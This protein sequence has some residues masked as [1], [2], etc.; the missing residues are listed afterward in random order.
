VTGLIVPVEYQSQRTLQPVP[1]I[2]MVCVKAKD[3]DYAVFVN[4]FAT[5]TVGT[6]QIHSWWYEDIARMDP[7]QE[8]SNPPHA[9]ISVVNKSSQ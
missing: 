1:G 7:A 2:I 4:F 5:H 8:Y 3:T 6:V 9:Y